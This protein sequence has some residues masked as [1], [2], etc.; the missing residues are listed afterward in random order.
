MDEATGTAASPLTPLSERRQVSVLF[1]DMVGFTAIR[2][3][4]P[5]SLQRG[6]QPVSFDKYSI[7]GRLGR[8]V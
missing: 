4:A 3:Q 6:A 8:N 5:L 1:A 7:A 2:R